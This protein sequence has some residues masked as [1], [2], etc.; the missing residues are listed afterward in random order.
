MHIDE[1]VFLFLIVFPSGNVKIQEHP[2]FVWKTTAKSTTW[3]WFYQIAECHL[4]IDKENNSK[5]TIFPKYLSILEL[6]QLQN[7]SF[8][9]NL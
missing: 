8:S 3:T 2:L 6:L 5:I 1:I 4:C 9:M 7:N